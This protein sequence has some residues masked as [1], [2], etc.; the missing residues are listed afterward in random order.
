MTAALVSQSVQL[1]T[2][3][4]KKLKKKTHISKTNMAKASHIVTRICTNQL[5]E[6]KKHDLLL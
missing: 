1:H 6:T 3:K 2:P 5:I 4:L